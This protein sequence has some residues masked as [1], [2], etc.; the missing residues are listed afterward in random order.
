MSAF[1]GQL[2]VSISSVKEK[3]KMASHLAFLSSSAL[4]I[5]TNLVWGFVA[6]G[7]WWQPHNLQSDLTV[8]ETVGLETLGW[9]RASSGAS[10]SGPRLIRFLPLPR[11][12]LSCPLWPKAFKFSPVNSKTVR[13]FEN[14]M[15][16]L[17]IIKEKRKEKQ[18]R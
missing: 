8:R 17:H 9:R 2:P 4:N 18:Y 12:P 6:S 15:L 3:H 16:G 13:C 11:I 1:F 14:R 5:D 10:C 7:F